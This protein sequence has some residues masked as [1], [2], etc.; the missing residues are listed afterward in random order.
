MAAGLG[1]RLRP[2]T[3]KVAKA[4][5]PVMG[6]P[7]IQFAAD[8]ATDVGIRELVVNVHAHAALFSKQLKAVDWRGAGLLLSDES[9]LLL[10]SAGGVRKALDQLKAQ[11]FLLLNADTL[12]NIDLSALIRRHQELAVKHDVWMTMAVFPESPLPGKYREMKM[13]DSSGL[14]TEVVR[15]PR[16][17]VPF[18]I[19]SAIVD[20]RAYNFL[21]GE[22]PREFIPEVIDRLLENRKLGFFKTQGVWLDVGSPE[23]WLRAHQVFMKLWQ[24]GKLPSAWKRRIEKMWVE[25]W[26]PDLFVGPVFDEATRKVWKERIPKDAQGFYFIEGETLSQWKAEDFKR[27]TGSVVYNVSPKHAQGRGIGFDDQWVLI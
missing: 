5:L 21:P 16:Q 10:G 18:F 6:V 4:S 22:E 27:T 25:N 3:E 24:E 17:K 26:G 11:S 14:I 8:A 1:T 23:L 19:G 7:M 9:R 2:F 12:S 15:E 13:D 20:R